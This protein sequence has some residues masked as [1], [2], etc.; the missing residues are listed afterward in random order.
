MSEKPTQ[1]DEPSDETGSDTPDASRQLTNRMILI[2]APA[3][4]RQMIHYSPELWRECDCQ[5]VG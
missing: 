5:F 3:W 4:V 2:G 1:P